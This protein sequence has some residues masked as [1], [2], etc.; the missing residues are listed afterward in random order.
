MVPPHTAQTYPA[1]RQISVN[2]MHHC[3]I[4]AS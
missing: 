4:D 1:K 2:E 3:L